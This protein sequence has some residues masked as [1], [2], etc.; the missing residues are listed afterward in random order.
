[1][2]K[3]SRPEAPK[4]QDYW[5]PA[6]TW[7]C[8]SRFFDEGDAHYLPARSCPDPNGWRPKLGRGQKTWPG[9]RQTR[10][11]RILRPGDPKLWLSTGN[12]TTRSLGQPLPGVPSELQSEPLTLAAARKA[13]L[14]SLRRLDRTPRTQATHRRVL[15][16]FITWLTERGAH[17][18]QDVAGRH[19]SAF[20]K[21]LAPKGAGRQMGV[22]RA[23]LTFAHLRDARQQR[24][25]AVPTEDY[26]GFPTQAVTGGHFLWV[27]VKDQ[28]VPLRKSLEGKRSPMIDSRQ[29]LPLQEIHKTRIHMPYS[30][31]LRLSL[32]HI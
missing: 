2:T 31:L 23:F 8:R 25:E 22:V 21:R 11:T 4:L 32:I 30:Q 10:L 20:Q 14:R 6:E 9:P 17:L 12:R 27:P 26:P 3:F 28:G 18:V 7:S 16:A 15:N 29:L 19:Q 13:Y 24:V 1:M 5:G